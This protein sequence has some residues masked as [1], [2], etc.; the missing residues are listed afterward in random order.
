MKLSSE[1]ALDPIGGTTP[2]AEPPIHLLFLFFGC[3]PYVPWT[4]PCL[5]RV[6]EKRPGS[7]LQASCFLSKFLSK[8]LLSCGW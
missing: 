2:V 4:L 8:M 5:A 7:L 6:R 3:L 1:I